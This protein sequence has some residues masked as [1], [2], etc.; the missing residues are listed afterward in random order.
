MPSPTLGYDLKELHSGDTVPQVRAL[1]KH[2]QLV[3]QFY[4]VLED[5]KRITATNEGYS[6]TGAPV[7]T[8]STKSIYQDII[9][10]YP[11]HADVNNLVRTVGS[12]MADC[13]AGNKDG[14]PIVFGDKE[15]K[16]T[17]ED[18]YE[19]WPL[20]RSCCWMRRRRR[21]TASTSSFCARPSTPSPRIERCW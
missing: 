17:L 3:R 9:G 15:T 11:Q 18:M 6:R 21:W 14:L 10:L 16:K 5:G 20:L 4:R 7:D 19:F 2:K 13:L 8:A 1:D 12:Q